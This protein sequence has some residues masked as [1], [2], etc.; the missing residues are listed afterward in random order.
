MSTSV[1][2]VMHDVT[3]PAR[4]DCSLY[5]PFNPEI[6]LLAQVLRHSYMAALENKVAARRKFGE[7]CE[8]ESEN[9]VRGVRDVKQS[10]V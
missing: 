1:I 7:K 3:G 8:S 10:D 5:I 6:A 9:S 4:Q 2:E